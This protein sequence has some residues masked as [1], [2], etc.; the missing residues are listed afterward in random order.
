MHIK[1]PVFE[2]KLPDKNK[3][4]TRKE[5]ESLVNKLKS[6]F[7]G[8]VSVLDTDLTIIIT[9]LFL[10][11]KDDF[12]LWAKTVF[13]EDRTASF[14]VKIYWLG[15]ILAHHRII[16]KKYDANLRKCI[17]RELD[18]V[19]QIRNDFA[20]TFTMT[21]VA[22]EIIKKRK[23]MLFDFEDGRTTTKVYGIENISNMIRNPF[24]H[25]ELNRLERLIVRIRREKR[26]ASLRR[27]QQNL[28]R[29]SWHP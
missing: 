28:E 7:L 1:T 3:V 27:M 13:D 12:S 26:T 6:N 2:L 19:R 17:I 10:R 11:D 21:D 4:L 8:H 23:I 15:K 14:G 29:R 5:Y 24:L 16:S 9:E 22:P 25:D 18:Q 20:H